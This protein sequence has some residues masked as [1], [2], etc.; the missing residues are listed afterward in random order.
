MDYGQWKD[1]ALVRET[2]FHKLED[3]KSTVIFMDC[4]NVTGNHARYDLFQRDQIYTIMAKCCSEVVE[5]LYLSCD[6]YAALDE[7]SV[8]FPDTKEL[9]SCFQMGDC[10]DYVLSLF[11]QRFLKLFWVY[12]PTTFVKST[13]FQYTQ[14]DVMR[15]LEYRKALCQQNALVWIAKEHLKKEE[16]ASVSEDTIRIKELLRRHGLLDATV[17]N[18]A[19]Y[20]GVLLHVDNKN[21]GFAFPGM[22]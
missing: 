17:A 22:I 13:I 20:E 18:S 9:K 16:Y 11:I 7:C 21:S 10:G 1:I 3:E 19:F 5:G 6:I 8:I 14:E 4:R 2:N 12:Y 15:Y